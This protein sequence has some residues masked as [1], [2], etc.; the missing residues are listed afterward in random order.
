MPKIIS[1]RTSVKEDKVLGVFQLEGQE[2]PVFLTDK[3]VAAATGLNHN[4][5]ILKGSTLD[6]V[7]YKKGDK[8]VNGT[9]VTD[10]NK[11]IKEFSFDL[12][13]RTANI[14]TAAAFGASMFKS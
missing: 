11:I 10:D 8:L 12:A 1:V 5:S 3:Q 9:E 14:A 7:Y 6:V 2:K 13:E 4:F